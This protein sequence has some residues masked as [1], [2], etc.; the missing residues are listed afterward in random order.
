VIQ[1]GDPQQATDFSE[2]V[3]HG[4]IFLRGLGVSTGV[5]VSHD[6]SCS[7]EP[8]CWPKDLSRMDDAALQTAD[9]DEPV[10]EEAV[11]GVQQQRVELL[12]FA[13]SQAT[14]KVCC[15][16]AGVTERLAELHLWSPKP[17]PELEGRE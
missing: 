12:A 6:E 2:S 15:R 5:V 1:E 7:C 4:F 8:D 11:L 3:G 14:K 16:V 17:P 10:S 13:G 9:A